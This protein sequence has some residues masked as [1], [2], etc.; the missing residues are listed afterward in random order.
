MKIAVMSDIHGNTLAFD[1]V[2]EDVKEKRCDSIFFLGDYMLAGYDPNG[3]VEKLIEI[4]K[5]DIGGENE[6]H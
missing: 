6:E 4:N 2:L 1:K 5:T 3:V